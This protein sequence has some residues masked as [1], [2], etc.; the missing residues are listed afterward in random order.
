MEELW[1]FAGMTKRMRRDTWDERARTCCET[2]QFRGP[3][4]AK[5]PIC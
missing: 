5:I 3:T 2:K 4:S 1:R